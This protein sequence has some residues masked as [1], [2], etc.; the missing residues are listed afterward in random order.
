MDAPPE[1]ENSA[2]FVDICG[3][4]RKA[5]L[6]APKIL[7]QNLQDGFIMLE[8]LGDGLYRD[9]LSEEEPEALFDPAFG[10]LAVMANEVDCSGLPEYD[11]ETLHD[12]LALYTDLYLVRHRGYSLRYRQ[13]NAWM[14]FCDELVAAALEQ[15][16]VFV[17]KD[18]HS[19]NLLQTEENSPGIIDFQ[20]AVSG[21]LSHD[22]VSLIWDRYIAWPRPQLELWME[23][24]RR[25]VA[26]GIAADK[27]IYY[28]DLMGLQ[29]NL[30]IVGRFAQLQYSHGKPGYIEMIPHFYQY[31]LD[32]LPRYPQFAGVA[33]WIGSDECAP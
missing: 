29:R 24:F 16:R 23:Q 25:M 7:E 27:W 2:S 22:F 13:R 10:S 26:P 31:I 32:A 8:D 33:E 19:C 5:G 30:R 28:C 14:K 4:L 18:F 1:K 17:H 9:L 15:P 11:E 6:H 3:R 20:D 21:P 12:E